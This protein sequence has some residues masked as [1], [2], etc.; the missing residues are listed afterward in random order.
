MKKASKSSTKKTDKNKKNYKNKNNNKTNQRREKISN[1]NKNKTKIEIKNIDNNKS[2]NNSVLKIILI[3]ILLI[4]ILGLSLI[5]IPK[6]K[7]NN[8]INKLKN[9]IKEN[10]KNFDKI[11]K[12]KILKDNITSKELNKVEVNIEKYL[13]DIVEIKKS[14]EQIKDYIKNIYKYENIINKE[15]Q[16]YNIEKL[17]NLKTDLINV[18]QKDVFKSDNKEY[19]KLYND[20]KKE[21]DTLINESDTDTLINYIQERKPILE[22]LE[23]N[24]EYYEFKEDIIIFKKRVKKEEFDKLITNIN[25]FIEYK[26]IE[27]KTAPIINA[28][29]ITIYKGDKLDIKSKIKCVDEVDDNVECK[30]SGTFN[31]SKIGEYKIT[32]TSEDKSKNESKKEIKII[33]KEKQVTQVA[34]VASNKPYYIEVIRNQNIV[35]IYGKDNNNQYTK[36]VKVF[37]A[38]TGRNN[39]TPLGT[40]KTTRGGN[41]GWLVG[42]VAGQYIT[43]FYGSYLFHSVPYYTNNKGKLEWEEYNKLGTQASAGCVRLT[44]RDAKW[45]YDN[46][47]NGTTVRIYD[48][49]I[50]KGITKPTAQKIPS[51]SP[52]RGWDPTDP[53]KNN[54]WNK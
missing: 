18:K 30:I 44:V 42:G 46:I 53:D 51:N 47:A 45:I 34:K 38:S 35:I 12:E 11:D 8:E 7:K 23:K 43:R 32:I 10:I 54:P 24:K 26:L 39:K 37:V 3:S 2:N 27:D 6:I 28:S 21:V 14:Y 33:V 1:N 40:Y 36:V 13:I 41:W 49:Q 50:P 20:L 22:Y 9:E 16:D 15:L 5:I 19:Q 31:S 52:N 48:G 29:N 25:D 17:D 4:F